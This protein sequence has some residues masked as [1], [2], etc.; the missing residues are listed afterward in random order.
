MI[1]A[2]VLRVG[3]ITGTFPPLSRAHLFAHD[4]IKSVQC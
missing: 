1:E 4:S 3:R 2:I